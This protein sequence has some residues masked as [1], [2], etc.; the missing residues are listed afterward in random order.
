M[1]L[2]EKTHSSCRMERD[3]TRT[4]NRWNAAFTTTLGAAG[5]E[6]VAHK[7]PRSEP[8]GL[9]HMGGLGGESVPWWSMHDQL[10]WTKDSS[11]GGVGGLSL[12]ANRPCNQQPQI[13]SEELLKKEDTLKNVM[14]DLSFN[15][16]IHH[17]YLNKKNLYVC[18][19]KPL[20]NPYPYRSTQNWI[21]VEHFF[22]VFWKIDIK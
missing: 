20:L 15:I 9:F 10:R 2:Q 22:P 14:I 5:T 16:N 18:P 3:S 19:C 21:L 17:L 7:Q 8:S 13:Q 11:W 12:G 4:I 1:D 6:Y